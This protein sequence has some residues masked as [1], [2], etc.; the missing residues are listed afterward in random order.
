MSDLFTIGSSGVTAYQRALSVV[1]NNIANVSTDGY[2]RQ[3]VSLASNSAAQYGAV[4]L[5]TG[6]RFES[7]RRQYD[8][9]VEQNLRNA[10]ADVKAQSPMGTYTNRLIDIM[11][12]ESVGLTSSMN[13]FFES[14]RNLATD[15]AS[16]VARGT[17]L[18]DADGLAARF[19]Q[20]SSQTDLID[21]E[22]R[23]ALETGVDQ[24]NAYS[25]QLAYVN[26]QLAKHNTEAKQPA[27]LLDQ[28]DLL[29]RRMSE[30]IDFNTKFEPNGAV[31]VSVGDTISRGVLVDGVNSKALGVIDSPTEKDKLTFIV[32]PY[33]TPETVAGV[34]SGQLGGLINY[35]E[36]VLN[37]SQNFIDDIA[38]VF[39]SYVNEIHH[40]GLDMDGLVG[41]DMF[42][43]DA[44]L[45]ASSM[46]MVLQDAT[47]I[48]A[49]GDFRIS[50]DQLNT[51][52]AQARVSYALPTYAQPSLL[53][54]KLDDGLTN[55]YLT[56]FAL[57][58]S[59]PAKPIGAVLPGQGDISIY[60][61]DAQPGQWL[62]VITRDGRHVAGSREASDAE[63]FLMG[64]AF[65]MESGA[66]YSP[67]ADN[68]GY[69]GMDIFI[70]AR[71]TVTEVQQFD[72]ASGKPVTPSLAS[73]R[74][75]ADYDPA[76]TFDG[77]GF[78]DST[79]TINGVAMA[80]PT[81]PTALDT[82]VSDAKSSTGVTG[83]YET[84]TKE[85]GSTGTRLALTNM[86]AV[87]EDALAYSGT[88]KS[89]NINELT[90]TGQDMGLLTA[91]ATL[92]DVAKWVNDS[93]LNSQIGIS[94]SVV[95]G[96]LTFGG[97][98][99]DV[100]SAVELA[101]RNAAGLV[102]FADQ[103]PAGLEI[104]G[105]AMTNVNQDRTFQD[106]INWINSESPNIGEVTAT[107]NDAGQFIL[108]KKLYD[109]ANNQIGLIRSDSDI[110]VGLGATGEPADL[111][112]LGFRTGL[113]IVGQ[114]TDDL[115]IAVTDFSNSAVNQVPTVLA[116]YGDTTPDVK[117]ILRE[118][119]LEI[120]FTS[121]TSYQITDLATGDVMAER[122]FDN[123]ASSSTISFRGLTVSLSSPPKAGDKFLIDGNQDGVGNNEAMLKIVN[124]EDNTALMG[125][126]LTMTET[127]IERV[128]D[129]GSIA[130]QTN[131]AEQALQVVYQ[132]ALET[133][134]GVSGVSIDQEAA[135]LVRYQQA[136][137]AN[138][139][140]M[141]VGSTL[142]DAILAVR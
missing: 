125:N 8:A 11:A 87:V 70:G 83:S 57:S 67:V 135:D 132:Q 4:Y 33:G 113:H 91:D 50:D 6:A 17:F 29:L 58:P 133:R 138:A 61:D 75:L 63:K 117:A 26:R 106:V 62:Q 66:S 28:R 101:V 9:F 1:S 74:M 116:T 98:T 90:I 43:I 53:M 112:A 14:A 35:R 18:R 54:D 38:Q 94:A 93:G 10:Q 16:L 24:V 104:D 49:A 120:E 124:L 127:Y 115:V 92:E 105:Y 81:S 76:A 51:G 102:N 23:Q 118:R 85:D 119:Q 64:D 36:Q 47:K 126:G 48:A 100:R 34:T 109:S 20:M 97:G 40:N 22:T 108:E 39:V 86:V 96:L 19:R 141:Q 136:Y 32:D 131:I 111:T 46:Q 25:T 114:A 72:P 99:A 71:A 129:I 130:R 13:L 15:P 103:F 65:G 110:R 80:A 44:T 73:A 107:A 59:V 27:E 140:V 139:K 52:A 37:P 137:Q 88:A 2:A 60:L 56:P 12:D 69:L 121:T 123:T 84:Y 7:V 77:L 134:D 68:T 95:N 79:F 128:N 89:W 42:Q 122:P 82:W 30:L 5:G 55:D 45:G 78:D 3:N 142:F 31:L 41:G 21:K